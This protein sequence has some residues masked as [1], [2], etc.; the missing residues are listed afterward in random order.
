[1]KS[2]KSIDK[3]QMSLHLSTEW[4]ELQV[5][6]EHF[7]FIKESIYSINTQKQNKKSHPSN[8]ETPLGF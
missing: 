3:F 5:L 8:L 6:I 7:F 1:M 4:E 2:I